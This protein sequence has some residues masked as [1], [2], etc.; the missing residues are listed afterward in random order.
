MAM[1]TTKTLA[2]VAAL[3]M[4]PLGGC[5]LD[6]PDLNNP[7][8]DSLIESPTPS[9]IGS[10]ATGLI[11]GSRRNY[12]QPNGYI[13][14]LGILG[15]ESYN[16]DAADPRFATEM[17]EAAQLDPGSPAFGGNFWTLPYRNLRGGL[18]ILA[19]LEI[20]EGMSDADKQ[21]TRGF[22][23]TMM[24][25]DYLHLINTRDR[26]GAVIVSSLE[27]GA[28][29]PIVPK[30]QVFAHIATILDEGKAH[31][32]GGG[33]A[34][35]FALSS[36][37]EGLDTPADFIKFN[38]ALKARVEIY[39]GNHQAALDALAE[40]F[41]VDDDEDPQLGLG[42]YHVY[43]S[44]PGDALNGLFSPTLYAHPSIVTD[45]DRNGETI[46]RRVSA[47]VTTV[48]PFTYSMI[49]SDKQFTIYTSPTAPAPIIRNEELILLRAEANIG[50][51]NVSA[52]ADDI[53]FV[54]VHAGGLTARTDLTAENILDELLKQRRYSLLFEGGHRWID[55]R[56]HGRLQ[57][58]PKDLATHSV[59]D[60]FPIPRA[61]QDA[62]Q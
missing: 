38:R 6:V 2:L 50:L 24:A 43:S 29:D 23:K 47:K 52:A 19:A 54:R 11:V 22:T 30:D 14:M 25:L 60:A 40:S 7:G 1:K 12:A 41:L 18:I 26:F 20:V 9:A 42:A 5:D 33:E 32:A 36:G 45:A 3:A 59:H 44:T 27:L 4:L 53:N 55:M 61:E 57:S 16:F 51:G 17:L 49:T 8:L 15:R 39:R 56:R 10:A 35:P 31:L 28:L 13:S 34:F 37:F 46:D 58:L 21:A 48:D 62:R